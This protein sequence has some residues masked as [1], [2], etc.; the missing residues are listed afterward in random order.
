[1][2]EFVGVVARA[3][4]LLVVAGVLAGCVGRKRTPTIHARG[5]RG[6]GKPCEEEGGFPAML[7]VCPNCGEESVSAMRLV[8]WSVKCKYCGARVGLHFVWSN[9]FYLFHASVL[10]FGGLYVLAMLG[11]TAGAIFAVIWIALGFF[12]F[13]YIPLEVK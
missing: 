12:H 4:F 8:F 13:L 6:T 2:R 3:G 7:R 5:S 9:L 10:I 11:F 1:M